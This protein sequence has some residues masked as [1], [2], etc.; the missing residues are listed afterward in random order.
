MTDTLDAAARAELARGRAADPTIKVV[1]LAYVR[2]AKPDL[3]ATRRFATDFGLL[4]ADETADALHLRGYGDAPF[5]YSAERGAAAAF[6]GFGLVAAEA[7]DLERVAALPGASPIETMREPGG[8]RRVRLTAPNGVCVDVVHGQARVEPRPMRPPLVV[9]SAEATPRRNTA[10][11]APSGP[12]QVKRLGHVVLQTKQHARV[13]SW[14]LRSFGMIVSDYQVL[15]QDAGPAIA[16]LRCDL[17]ATPVDHHTVALAAGFAESYEHAAFEVQDL[18]ALALGGEHLRQRGWTRAW[19]IGRHILG[20]QL[21][22]YWRDPD[23]MLIEHYAD[24]DRFDA[25]TPTGSTPFSRHS[26]AQWGPP[27]PPDFIDTSMTPRKAL[28]IV[29]ALAGD[30]DFSLKKLVG[31]AKA[32]G[33]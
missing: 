27:L 31:M 15:P 1:D 18:D 29:S 10:Q 11:R 30:S 17:G 6:L 24:G 23:G 5:C 28:Q 20:S 22:D 4:A 9:N 7:R 26:L 8:G 13:L 14:L 25:A 16:F 2:F 32:M 12:A 33:R 19:G 21:F 3:D